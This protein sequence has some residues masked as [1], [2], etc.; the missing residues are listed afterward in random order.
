MLCGYQA[1]YDN[2]FFAALD[3]ARA[4]HFAYVSFDLNVPR[5]YI[6]RLTPDEL[7]QIRQYAE[8]VGVGLAFH[9]PG[10]N[11]SLYADYP[12]IRQG[13]LAHFTTVLHAA[14]QL[15]AR[16]VTL[17]TGCCPSFKKS[18]MHED[19]F[20]EEYREYFSAVLYENLAQLAGETSQV[21]LCVENYQFTSPTMQT[22]ARLLADTDRL[23]L[24]WDIAKT[25]TQ[26]LQLNKPVAEF[27]WQHRDRVC[28]VH[29]H[30]INGFRSH[31]TI[32]EGAID[33]SQYAMLLLRP[34]VAVTIEVRP[35][36]AATISRDK[37]VAMLET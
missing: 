26:P 16:H 3:Y 18:G 17:H 36:E 10:D 2:D 22:V 27:M 7:A 35:R 34:D 6:D 5:F 8:E 12:A 20:S 15:H 21:M 30:D 1:V 11:V 19:A 24:T 32:G 29:A 37:L 25:Y 9:L 33:F 4:H 31:Q 23:F 14:E 13:I 28:E